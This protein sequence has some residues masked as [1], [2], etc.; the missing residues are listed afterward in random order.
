MNSSMNKSLC[1]AISRELLYRGIRP[2]FYKEIG[3]METGAIPLVKAFSLFL[4]KDCFYV[5]KERKD[6]G[7][8][9]VIE[10]VFSAQSYLLMDDVVTT[11]YN[12]WRVEQTIGNAKAKFC[13]ID[14]R[15]DEV[16][17]YRHDE[18]ISLFKEKDFD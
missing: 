4:D 6:Y 7:T 11:G 2:D 13:I 12:M 10:G 3:G 9:K 17:R 8:Q 16:G 18:I 5:R 14:R 15:N 1:L